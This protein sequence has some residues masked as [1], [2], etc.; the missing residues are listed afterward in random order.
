MTRIDPIDLAT[1][2]T[3]ASVLLAIVPTELLV[4]AALAL[5]A[6]LLPMLPTVIAVIEGA[7]G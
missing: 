4:A 2:R 5:L 6:L 7:A 3:L 1:N